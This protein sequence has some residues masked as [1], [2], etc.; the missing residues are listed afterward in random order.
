VIEMTRKHAWIVLLLLATVVPCSGQAQP[1]V[2]PGTGLPDIAVVNISLS[3]PSPLEDEEVRITALIASNET[4]PVGNITVHFLVDQVEIGNATSVNLA[5][6]GRR[7]ISTNW[8]AVKWDHIV[9]ITLDVG[10]IP[11][12]GGALS[13]VFSVK[14]EPIGNVSTLVYAL[15][16]VIIILLAIAIAPS[17]KARLVP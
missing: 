9:T 14:A 16:S 3:S 8:T 15:A 6:E 12:L 13:V 7:D 4:L 5:A 10:G 1:P 17:V 2:E 11:I